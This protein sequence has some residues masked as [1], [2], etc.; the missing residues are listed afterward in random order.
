M[1]IT[2]AA[3]Q[4]FSEDPA[5]RS[6]GLPTY[7]GAKVTVRGKLYG[8]ACFVGLEPRP[9]SAGEADKAALGHLVRSIEQVFGRTRGDRLRELR[10]SK[11]RFEALLDDPHILAGVL[12]PDG[13]LIEAN[14]TAMEYIAAGPSEVEG[15]LFWEM[16]WWPDEVRSAIRRKVRKATEGTRVQYDADL[17]GPDGEPCA[18]SGAICPVTNKAGE[19]TSLVVTARDITERKRWDEELRQERRGRWRVVV[20]APVDCPRTSSIASFFSP[21]WTR[22][23]LR[24]LRRDLLKTG[25]CFALG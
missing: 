6:Y 2:D 10:Q 14:E 17:T 5:Y 9:E 1:A 25:S 19:V 18:L 23:V 13:T 3:G 7:F 22:A 8:T 11:R 15:E 20:S 21:A 4:G 16:P 24:T 12:A